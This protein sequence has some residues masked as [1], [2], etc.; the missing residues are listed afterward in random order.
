MCAYCSTDPNKSPEQREVETAYHRLQD[1]L[2]RALR[3]A[4][5]PDRLAGAITALHGA[6]RQLRFVPEL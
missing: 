5:A 2:E 6:R 3:K 1:D 4:S